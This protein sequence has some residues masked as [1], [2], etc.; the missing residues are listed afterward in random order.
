MVLEVGGR[1]LVRQT[2]SHKRLVL[3]EW[4]YMRGVKEKFVLLDFLD[5][6]RGA[7]VLLVQELLLLLLGGLRA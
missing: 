1:G 5:D 4:R 6:D 2:L 3:V 7:L